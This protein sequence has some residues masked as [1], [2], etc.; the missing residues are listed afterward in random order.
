MNFGEFLGGKA[1]Q[2]LPASLAGDETSLSDFSILCRK[3][4]QKLLS[5]FA[6]GLDVDS[7]PDFFTPHHPILPT[8]DAQSGSIL[9]LLYY[10]PLSTAYKKEID[11]R[12]GA[13]SD[14]G[15]VTLL[16]Q[17]PGQSGLQI[18]TSTGDWADVPAGK[19]G[20]ILIN[21]GDLLEYWTAGVLKSTVHRVIFPEGGQEERYSMAYFCHP[22]DKTALNP[23]PSDMV[24]E[25]AK[26]TG[27]QQQAGE[28]GSKAMTAKQHLHK[29]LAET[30]GWGKEE[31][32]NPMAV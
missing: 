20:D 1:Q 6:L 28:D 25:H 5:L 32:S 11:I 9:R 29:R 22:V 19:D 14:Y 23:V 12:A 30:Y 8:E 16:F 15:S 24:R 7:G 2:P 10:P 27:L 13:H 3:L 17:R 4:C 31:T 21:I 26:S 18:L